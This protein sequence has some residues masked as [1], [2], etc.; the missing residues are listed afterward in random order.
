M[1]SVATNNRSVLQTII[2]ADQPNSFLS[3][4]PSTSY[5]KDEQMIEET[6]ILVN[7]H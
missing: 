6:K 7:N 3:W 2:M 1:F 4:D 5:V